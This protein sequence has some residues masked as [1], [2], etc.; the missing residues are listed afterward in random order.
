VGKGVEVPFGVGCLSGLLVLGGGLTALV[1]IAA[2]LG[3]WGLALVPLGLP[4][5]IIT[6]GFLMS[7]GFSL[8][9]FKQWA[10]AVYV[11]IQAI[12]V[13]TGVWALLHFQFLALIDVAINL[14]VLRYMCSNQIRSL[15]FGPR[16]INPPK[17]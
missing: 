14:L 17:K 16:A 7:L 9:D 2:A 15:Y 6:G 3:V 11:G 4:I 12:G 10:Y 5:G 1:T 13:V 8:C